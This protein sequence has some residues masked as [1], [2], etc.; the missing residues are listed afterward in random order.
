M[1]LRHGTHIAGVRFLHY[2]QKRTGGQG[3]AEMHHARAHA[4]QPDVVVEQALRAGLRHGEDAG[5]RE[6]R[7]G[8]L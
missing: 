2:P 3:T 5:R 1:H 6:V 8:Q 4:K 7:D